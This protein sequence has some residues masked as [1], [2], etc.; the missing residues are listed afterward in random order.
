MVPLATIPWN[1]LKDLGAVEISSDEEGEP[2]ASATSGPNAVNM[3]VIMQALKE[4]QKSLDC[5]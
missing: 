2:P 3:Q 5:I 1:P 4:I